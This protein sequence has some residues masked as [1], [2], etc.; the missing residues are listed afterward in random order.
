MITLYTS[1]ILAVIGIYFILILLFNSP[2]QPFAVM[3]AIPFGITG[4]ILA[5]KIHGEPFGFIAMLGVIGLIGVLVNDSLVL[6]NHVN[7]LR[8]K[9]RHEDLKIL[10]SV[11]TSNRLRPILMTTLTTVAGL[12]PLAYGV[13]GK[14]PYMAPMA[15]A[16]TWGLVFATPITLLLVPNLYIIGHDIARVAKRLRGI[17]EEVP[18]S[19]EDELRKFGGY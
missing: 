13:G 3:T 9:K 18:E 5:F 6:V 7:D 19:I 8:E 10:V 12:M 11:G 15:L 16:L 1:F 2:F 17:K 14:D 4:V